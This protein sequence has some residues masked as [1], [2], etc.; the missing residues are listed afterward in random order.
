MVQ[1][2][3]SRQPKLGAVADLP[4]EKN[5]ARP[6]VSANYIRDAAIELSCGFFWRGEKKGRA[7]LARV[8]RSEEPLSRIFRDTLAD[9]IQDRSESL[10]ILERARPRGRR[11]NPNRKIGVAVMIQILKSKEPERK[12][13]SVIEE[14]AAE[15]GLK[16]TQVLE[17]WKKYKGLVGG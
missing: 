14:V 9:L 13:E 7:A 11:S 4:T 10:R 8:L 5:T 2:R 12:Q 6:K 17:Y 1:P 3:T 16:R 15:F